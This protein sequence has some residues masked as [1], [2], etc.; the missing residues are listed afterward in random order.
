MTINTKHFGELE[1][2]EDQIII[3]DEGLPGFPEDKKFVLLDNEEPFYWLQSADDGNN[4]FIL[5]DV[6]SILP[7]YN[8][9]VDRDDMF[10]LGEYNP[11]DFLIYNIVVLPDNVED[12]TVNLLAPVVINQ[13]SKKGRQIIAKNEEYGVKHYMLKPRG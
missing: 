2:S 8:P 11:D 6:F 3:F 13:A 9:Q 5:A 1:I 10:P 12:M 4:A 7:D